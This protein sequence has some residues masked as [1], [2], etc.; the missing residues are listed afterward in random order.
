MFFSFSIVFLAIGG[1]V[2]LISATLIQTLK[3]RNAKEHFQRYEKAKRFIAPEKLLQVQFVSAAFAIA[4]VVLFL[5]LF[6]VDIIYVIV[7]AAVLFGFLGYLLPFWFYCWKFRKRQELIESKLLRET[8][9]MVGMVDKVCDLDFAAVEAF[10][11]DLPDSIDYSSEKD[12]ASLKHGLIERVEQLKSSAVQISILHRNLNKQGV[13]P[14]QKV[15]SIDVFLDKNTMQRVYSFDLFHYDKAPRISREEPQGMY[16]CV[17]GYEFMYDY[18]KNIH[19]DMMSL[20]LDELPFKPQI[21][22]ARIVFSDIE[23]FLTYV[24]RDENLWFHNGKLKLFIEYCRAVLPLKE[25]IIAQ[26]KP[27][28]K[29][30]DKRAQLLAKGIAL[31]F[32]DSKT[33]SRDD[34]EN[35]ANEFMKLGNNVRKM[36]REY[37]SSMPEEQI[38]IRDNILLIGFPG[39]PNVKQMWKDRPSK[40]RSN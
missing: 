34:A 14:G 39:D 9:R 4:L 40:M 5:T 15:P 35:L 8:N 23:K 12:I 2:Y 31:Y 3:E 20:N 25:E 19:T 36:Y 38:K 27:Y 18:L 21:Y 17:V 22:L 10:T 6:K 28:F 32:K 11:L 26:C 29:A 30:K 1:V 24:D 13:I 37:A 16:D 33:T 7:F